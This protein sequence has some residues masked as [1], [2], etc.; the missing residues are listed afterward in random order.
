MSITA[1]PLTW[2]AQFPRSRYRER[3]RLKATLATAISNVNRSLRGFA[4]DSGKPLTGVVISSNVTLGRDKPADPGVAVWF[5]WDAMQLCIPVDRYDT[6]ASNLQAIHHILEA[7]RTE[8]RHGSLTLVK[9]TFTGFTSLPPPRSWRE[10]MGYTA[11]FKPAREHL[12][13]RFRQMAFDRH[14]DR[15]GSTA[16]MAELNKAREAARKELGL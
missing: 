7:R 12:D 8:L 13:Q 15:G 1:H 16:A 9:A 3:G 11:G 6:V 2:P 5:T 14:P 10:V 4:K